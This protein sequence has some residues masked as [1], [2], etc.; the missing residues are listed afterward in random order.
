MGLEV[1][2]VQV[3]QHHWVIEP[4]NGP[5]SRGLCRNCGE[6]RDFLNY[7]D[8]SSWGSDVSLDQ[9]AGGSRIP[10]RLGIGAVNGFPEDEDN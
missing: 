1:L 9:L 6:S 2:E 8:G 10:T 4:P 5:T 7:A 3:C